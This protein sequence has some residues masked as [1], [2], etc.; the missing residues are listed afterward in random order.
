[1]LRVPA[2]PDRQMLQP[3]VQAVL[4]QRFLQVSE[5]ATGVGRR[6]TQIKARTNQS[7]KQP[8]RAINLMNKS[9]VLNVSSAQ[10]HLGPLPLAQ[11]SF[12]RFHLISLCI[13]NVLIENKKNIEKIGKT[14]EEEEAK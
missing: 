1:M 5:L 3:R 6:A 10:H 12:V 11:E 13:E 8:A 2:A 14:K 9:Q 4:S 7:A